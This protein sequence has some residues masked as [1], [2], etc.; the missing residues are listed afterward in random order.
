MKKK[1]VVDDAGRMI[2]PHI[3]EEFPQVGLN[4]YVNELEGKVQGDNTKGGTG[5]ERINQDSTG[6]F[7]DPLDLADQQNEPAEPEIQQPQSTKIGPR[8]G[9]PVEG[10]PDDL[11]RSITGGYQ[12]DEPDLKKLG[13]P[14]NDEPPYEKSEG[15]P[16]DNNPEELRKL[17]NRQNLRSHEGVGDSYPNHPQT[18]DPPEKYHRDKLKPEDSDPRLPMVDPN[19]NL[20]QP[21]K[22]QAR[23]DDSP[24][25][26]QPTN[27]PEGI[28]I[29]IIKIH[30]QMQ[31]EKNLMT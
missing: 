31:W 2:E 8:V 17:T 11:G 15:F 5:D 19:K 29:D 9:E 28:E 7:K 10:E 24:L 12:P 4:D 22:G 14:D 30:L 6:D 27:D 18:P 16:E 26:E 23:L 3:P 25:F 1:G 13:S 21:Q 20:N